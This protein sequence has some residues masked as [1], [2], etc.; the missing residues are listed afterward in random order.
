[1]NSILLRLILVKV[2]FHT[3]KSS[4]HSINNIH[5]LGDSIN[6]KFRDEKLS[7][8]DKRMSTL[9]HTIFGLDHYPNYLYRFKPNS[10][11]ELESNLIQALEKFQLQKKEVLEFENI[12]SKL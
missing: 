7:N 6:E 12:R 1:M 2:L 9:F 11:L 4:K 8:S 3:I 5:M 10:I